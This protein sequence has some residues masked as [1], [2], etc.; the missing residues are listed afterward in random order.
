M[1]IKSLITRNDWDN[2]NIGFNGNP[3]L[4]GLGIRL[5]YYTQ[6]LA[7]CL[8][9]FIAPREARFL[10]T[11]ST[12]FM[13]AVIACVTYLSSNPT[14]IFA[15]EIYLLVHI[16]H[17]AARLGVYHYRHFSRTHLIIRDITWVIFEAFSLW[18]WFF[19]L[20][21][22]KPTPGTPTY[23]WFFNRGRFVISLTKYNLC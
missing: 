3:D 10:Q 22:L 20:D 2:P 18:F 14:Q 5:G 19:A 7:L 1:S 15:V 8:A 12:M 4:Y 17:M 6:A 9:N 16:A 21:Y 13:L 11:T 23:V